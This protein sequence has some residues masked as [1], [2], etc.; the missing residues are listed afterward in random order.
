MFQVSSFCA[1]AL[2]ELE[3]LAHPRGPSLD[4]FVNG[5]NIRSSTQNSA[6]SGA[7]FAS[8]IDSTMNS[9]C[10]SSDAMDSDVV[11]EGRTRADTSFADEPVDQHMK[12]SEAAEAV[13]SPLPSSARANVGAF[14]SSSRLME[15]DL[16]SHPSADAISARENERQRFR[17][18]AEYSALSEEIKVDSRLTKSTQDFVVA[19]MLSDFVDTLE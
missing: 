18:V 15:S 2:T 10:R 7:A 19:S 1:L 17:P 4:L 16:P 5:E 13:H 12:T 6:P 3:G 11:D 8:Q 9:V 14:R